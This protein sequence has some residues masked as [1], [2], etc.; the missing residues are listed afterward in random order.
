MKR[1][2]LIAAALVASIGVAVE[3]AAAYEIATTGRTLATPR[4]AVDVLRDIS[5]YSKATGGCSFI[6]SAAMRIE[7]QS[8]TPNGGHAEIWTLNVCAAK[9]RFRITMR[10][11]P[12]GGSDYTIQPM[13]G[14]M[15]LYVQ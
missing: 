7:P 10:P 9:Q 12:R 15:P 11:S 5:A 4:L 13:T 1:M 3:P 2:T 14:R 6:Y 8:F